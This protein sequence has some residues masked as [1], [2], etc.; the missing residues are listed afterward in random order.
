[1]GT[2][3]G[4][5]GMWMH[6]APVDADDCRGCPETGVMAPEPP[7]GEWGFPG[8]VGTEFLAQFSAGGSA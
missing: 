4:S 5:P 1:M 3:N 2:R 8:E 7:L 6:R